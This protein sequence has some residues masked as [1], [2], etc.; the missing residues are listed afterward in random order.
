MPKAWGFIYM[1]DSNTSLL[2]GLM[3]AVTLIGARGA[4]DMIKYLLTHVGGNNH[5]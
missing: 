5:P 2:Q 3:G 4:G 1:T